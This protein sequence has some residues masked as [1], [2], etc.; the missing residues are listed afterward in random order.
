MLGCRARK[1]LVH[2]GPLADL[3]FRSG[4]GVA[5][6]SSPLKTP[7]YGFAIDADAASGSSTR[8]QRPYRAASAA[9][10]SPSLPRRRWLRLATGLFQ[11]AARSRSGSAA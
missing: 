3:R 11:R 8:A 5:R 6:A 4:A 10:S 1:V 9:S 2:E 7:Y